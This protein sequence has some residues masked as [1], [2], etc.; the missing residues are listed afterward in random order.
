[1]AAL[2]VLFLLLAFVGTDLMMR[3]ASKRAQARQERL[4]RESIL[5]VSIRLDRAPG[6]TS[7]QRVEVPDPKARILVVDDEPIVLDSFRRILVLE[8]YDVDTVEHGS[9]ALFLVERNDY[10]FVFT[11]LNMPGMDGLELLR[12][13]KH[14]RPDI[15]VAVVTGYATL[16]TAVE[17]MAQGASD[18]LRKP[19]SAEEVLVLL[20]RLATKREARLAGQPRALPRLLPSLDSEQGSEGGGYRLPGGSFISTGHAWVRIEPGGEVRVGIDDF[21]QKAAGPVARVAMPREGQEIRMGDPLFSLERGSQELHFMAPLSGRVVE[22]NRE[23]AGDA[24]PLKNSPY[25]DGWVCRI[26]PT[27]LASE[28]PALRIGKPVLGWYDQEIKR[29]E[30][31]RGG[32]EGLDW[33]EFEDEFLVASR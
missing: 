5:K 14:L 32:K 9:E 7:L 17:T 3:E 23:L 8:G 15:D 24:D 2:L 25:L 30:R 29:L 1:M 28:L 27:D 26:Q 18:C 16:E 19:F 4:H 21:A 11:D 22:G 10:D 12:A 33:A 6:A 20:D 31:L 13:V